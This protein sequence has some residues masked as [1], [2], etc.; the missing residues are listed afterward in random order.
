MSK[1][2]PWSLDQKLVRS[3]KDIIAAPIDTDLVIMSI[4][5]GCYYGASIVG[6]RIWQL[7]EE[8]VTTRNMCQRLLEEFEVE[9]SICEAETTTFLLQLYKEGLLETI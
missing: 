4:E 7:L 9:P 2:I 8:P 3:N 6:S 5:K 1:E